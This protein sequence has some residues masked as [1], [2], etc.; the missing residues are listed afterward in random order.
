MPSLLKKLIDSKDYQAL[1]NALTQN[2]ALA[3]EGIEYDEKN[4]SKA[5]PLHRL[6]DGVF[7]GTYTDEEAVQMAGL[8]LE[9][10]ALVDG[11]EVIEKRD[12]PLI[13]AASL[14]A[15]KLAI[16]YIEKGANIKHAGT[17][18]GTALHWA[19]W[20]G[21]PAVVK[22]LVEACADINKLCLDFTSTPL[23]WAVHGFVHGGKNDL[24]NYLQCVQ[25]L[26]NAGADKSIPN[27][28]GKTVLDL[29]N[30]EDV[31]LKELLK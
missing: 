14:H 5:H 24:D 27:S 3:N 11:N 21:R 22:R 30:V 26:L 4:A 19:A 15:D 12:T 23:F 10:G 18:G 7:A 28:G 20:C 8:F 16:F 1:K 31:E 29:L 13:A 9:Y 2:P 17:H 25:I 6:C